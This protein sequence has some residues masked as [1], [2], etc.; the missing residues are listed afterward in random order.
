MTGTPDVLPAAPPGGA[1]IDE[2]LRMI[3]L[4]MRM[5][6]RNGRL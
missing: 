4:S 6:S 2:A 1:L 3:R 5:K